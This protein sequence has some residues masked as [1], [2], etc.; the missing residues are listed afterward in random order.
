[1]R[2]IFQYRWHIPLVYLSLLNMNCVFAQ[3]NPKKLGFDHLTIKDKVLGDVHYYHF[4]KGEDS[5]KPLLL[6]LDGSGAYPLFQMME[7]GTG[8]TIPFDYRSLAD[9]YHLLFIS[10]PGVP[11]AD[12]VGKDPE[13]NYPLYQT[14]EEYTRRLSLGW[15]VQ[16]A[17]LV[18]K[19]AL[20]KWKVNKSKIAVLGFSEG[21]QVGS[22]LISINPYI[23]HAI[24]FV[25]NG[26]TQFFDFIIQNRLD[27]QLGKISVAESQKNI[28]SLY[29]IYK[30]IQSDPNSTK[31]FWYG[32][33]YLRWSS[34]CAEEPI[35][36]LLGT[37]IPVYFVSCN[38]D[39]NTSALGLD[40]IY[41][42]AVLAGKKNLE[43][44]TYPYD[45]GFNEIISDE[46]GK[47]IS[48][49]NHMDDAMKEAIF[50]LNNK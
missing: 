19:D 45:H 26:F 50:W 2:W 1:M 17:D 49:K 7:K 42:K 46:H 20:K 27:A 11:F 32:H 29:A 33:S 12:S 8:S 44:R 48:V 22:K 41:L 9:K 18:L 3:M 39:Q 36:H 38:N 23:T 24:L 4:T 16:S 40:Y 47:T 13:T 30:A 34:F 15:R 25:G 21:F 35:N 5:T 43:Y 14:P 6:Y 37:K 28:D 10:K 31:K